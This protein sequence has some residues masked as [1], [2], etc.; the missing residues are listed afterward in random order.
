MISLGRIKY[1]YT[2][3]NIDDNETA[4]LILQNNPSVS[5]IK[6]KRLDGI[7]DQER[8]NETDYFKLMEYNI[9]Q[10]KKETYK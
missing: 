6:L 3:E 9:E 10:I 2:L 5:L 4:N 8:S 7:T 1:I